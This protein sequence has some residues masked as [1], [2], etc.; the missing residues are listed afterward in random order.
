MAHDTY[1]GTFNQA[2]FE[3]F[4]NFARSQ[5]PLVADRLL[6]LFAEQNRI[7]VVIFTY[8]NEGIPTG[9]SASPEDSYLAK[10]LAAYEVLGGNPFIDLRVR[11]KT[12]PVFVV[13]GD[14]NVPA[15]QMSSGE[16]MA[17]KGLSD[18]GTAELV[19]EARAW[20]DET[21]WHRSGRLERRIRRALDY[22]DSL[23]DEIDYLTV[24][25]KAA[26]TTDSFE[27]LAAQLQEWLNDPN[28]LAAMALASEKDAYGLKNY[29][30]EAPYYL[31]SPTTAG[32]QTVDPNK[33][34]R[35]AAVLGTQ[36]QAGGIINPG[37]TE[38]PV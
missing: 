26:T 25:Q 4:T 24:I 11:V 5:M 32:G 30:P 12:T 34:G 1:L 33:R 18:A 9:Y 16:V 15:H 28:Y 27:D 36:K 10:L 35:T 21:L 29:A 31:P 6:H 17:N 20:L 14:E 2:Q 8:D 37:Q 38:K 22:Y 3:R 23:Q 13:A 7:G 19:R